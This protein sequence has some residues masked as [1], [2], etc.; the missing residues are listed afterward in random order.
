VVRVN[1]QS[2]KGGVAYLMETEHGMVLPRRLQIEFSRTIQTITEDTGTEISP[3]ELWAAFEAEYLPATPLVRL[4]GHELVTGSAGSRITAQLFVDGRPMRIAGE[5]SGPLS[6]FVHGITKDLG[7]E[8]S[9]HDY[10]EHAVSA[11]TDAQAVAYVEAEGPDGAIRWGVG[12]DQSI[13]AASLSA[14]VS[15]LNRL[16]TVSDRLRQLPRAG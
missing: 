14:V 2:G 3:E 5:G 11:G 8:L 1:S 12:I 6:A 13:I 4:A 10:A 16:P 15:A 7:V 9:V